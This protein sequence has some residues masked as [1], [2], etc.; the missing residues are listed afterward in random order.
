MNNT[1][2]GVTFDERDLK[3]AKVMLEVFKKSDMKLEGHQVLQVAEVFLWMSRELLPKIE[4]NIL[5][6]KKVIKPK[7]SP[8]P[9]GSAEVETV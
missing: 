8:Q 5:E 1:G 4:E 7:D 9:T 6:L 3:L 2:H